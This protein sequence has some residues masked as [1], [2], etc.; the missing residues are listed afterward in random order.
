[1]PD[2]SCD[3][4]ASLDRTLETPSDPSI[5]G[6]QAPA[7]FRTIANVVVTP[8]PAKVA[9]RERKPPLLDR[10]VLGEEMGRG[11]TAR[12]FAAYDPRW[13]RKV[14]VK[15]M[16]TPDGSNLVRITAF[17]NEARILR[18]LAHPNIVP[19]LDSGTSDSGEPYLVMP[20]L[21]GENLRTVLGLLRARAWGQVEA[22]PMRRRLD[23]FLAICAGVAK[24]H[25]R[26]I[27]HRDLK[28]AN[29]MFSDVGVP[30]VI[31]WGLA[32]PPLPSIASHEDGRRHIGGGTPG[33]M[34]PE[35][36][37][38][39]A[40]AVD[41]RSDVWGLGAILYEL[42]TLQRAVPGGLMERLNRTVVGTPTAPRIRVPDILVPRPLSAICMQALALVPSDRFDSVDALVRAVRSSRC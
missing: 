9:V 21:D 29:V 33:Y 32:G 8:D 4:V 30:L 39:G 12:V 25:S 41:H 40:G 37:T 7:R 28:P 26:G 17:D 36:I 19:L 15:L 31:D 2:L 38:Y 6:V 23:T 10:Y 5:D 27:V 11:A 18:A 20:L 16:R 14:A 22:W 24:A 13:D 1:M 35:Q 3:P 34:S 42:L